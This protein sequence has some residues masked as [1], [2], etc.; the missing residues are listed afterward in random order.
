MSITLLYNVLCYRRRCDSTWAARPRGQAGNLTSQRLVLRRS[1]AALVVSSRAAP[2]HARWTAGLSGT[3][4]AR[5]ASAS[6]PRPD[7]LAN[8][9]SYLRLPYIHSSRLA[10]CL[11]PDPPATRISELGPV[12][13]AAPASP[14]DSNPISHTSSFALRRLWSRLVRAPTSRVAVDIADFLGVDRPESRV[15]RIQ[16]AGATSCCMPGVSR[17]QRRARL[18]SASDDRRALALA[19]LVR[20]SPTRQADVSRP[21][22]RRVLPSQ[23]HF[24][25]N[26]CAARG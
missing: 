26:G 5:L 14:I 20:R 4:V 16:L 9:V 25:V 10:R 23:I 12:H 24:L 22:H 15:D 8:D 19:R 2:D 1:F 17:R 7:A 3:S 11:D 13:A 21:R 6:S 18:G